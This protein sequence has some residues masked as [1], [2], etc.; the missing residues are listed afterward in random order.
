MIFPVGMFFRENNRLKSKKDKETLERFKK[1]I[2]DNTIPVSTTISKY[3]KRS[4]RSRQNT[5]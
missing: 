2:F 4:K 5:T 1:D 3:R